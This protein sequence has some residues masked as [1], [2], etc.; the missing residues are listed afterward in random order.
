MAEEN[1]QSLPYEIHVELSSKMRLNLM[2]IHT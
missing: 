1:L 2:F